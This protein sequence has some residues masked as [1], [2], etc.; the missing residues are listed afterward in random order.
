MMIDPARVIGQKVHEGIDAM[1]RG[2]LFLEKYPGISG[3]L[4]TAVVSS[5]PPIYHLPKLEWRDDM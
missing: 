1:V 2:D 3:H 4:W 5:L